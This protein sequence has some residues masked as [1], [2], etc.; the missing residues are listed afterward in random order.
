MAT[1]VA[2]GV[3]FPIPIMALVPLRQHLL[4]RWFG[5]GALEELDRMEEEVADPLPHQEAAILAEVMSEVTTTPTRAPVDSLAVFLSAT[6][7]GGADGAA[8]G[9]EEEGE[10]GAPPTSSQFRVV[11]HVTSDQI[12]RRRNHNGGAP[13]N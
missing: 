8:E 9:E 4:P 10:E 2:S 1:L 11:Q 5:S 13:G 6:E 3:L 12:A 7:G